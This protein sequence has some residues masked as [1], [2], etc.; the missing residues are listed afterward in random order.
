MSTEHVN[1]EETERRLERLRADYDDPPVVESTFD[2]D[3]S[4]FAEAT[5]NAREGYIGGGYCWVVR[6]PEQ[7]PPLSPSMPD[8]AGNDHDRVLLILSRGADDWGLPGGGL[9]GYEPAAV[10]D[11][12]PSPDDDAHG[13]TYEEAAV[14]EVAEETG[15]ECRITG[16]WKIERGYWEPTDDR[17]LRLHSLY[18][19]F[20]AE[21]V[22]GHPDLQP[23]ELD[24]AGWFR[25]M[26][27]RLHPA[28]EEKAAEWEP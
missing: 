27:E 21:Y 16:C 6:S 5:A 2:V 23:G 22:D 1:R 26:P 13:E 11:P 15:V 20:E 28:N 24:G 18:V 17:D 9:E 7:A 3:P 4:G 12:P 14:R 19:F 8:D 25:H 10:S